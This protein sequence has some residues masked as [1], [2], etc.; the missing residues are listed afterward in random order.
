VTDLG[1]MM[2]NES[3]MLR[4]NDI[5]IGDVFSFVVP[6]LQFIQIP[7]IGVLSTSDLMLLAALPIAILRHPERLNRKPVP[8]ILT[9]GFFWFLGQVVTD[10]VRH[11][12]PEDYLR[13]WSKIF[14]LLVNFTVVWIVACRN[15]GR[16]VLYSIGLGMGAILSVYFHPSD[17]AV[18]SPWKF[19]LGIPV[20]LLVAIWAAHSGKH[21]YVGILLPLT[22]LAIVHSF[23]NVRSIALIT[24]ITAVYSLFQMSQARN[25]ARVGKANLAVL[26]LTVACGMWSFMLVYSHYVEQGIF[27][28]YAQRK[29]EIQKN[30]AA[31]LLLGGRSEILASGQAILDSPLLG[32]GSWARDPTYAAI[33]AEKR[34]ELGYKNVEGPGGKKD[35]LIPSHSHIFGGWV[36]AGVA[37][38]MFWLFVLVYTIGTLFKV[39][40]WEPLL[41]LFAFAGFLLIWDILFSPLGAPTRFISPYFMAAMVVLASL[42]DPQA[43]FGDGA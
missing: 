26:S 36:E 7:A 11:S 15:R 18:I 20:T 28:E 2:E 29:L 30:G 31:G 16:F 6:A 13:G 12:S 41:P 22:I 21:K 33:L 17:D 35:D 8:T 3:T 42:R 34:A 37:G 39:S 19:G 9:L 5:G 38:A 14:L 32:H 27:G 40:G 10:L 43:V 23:Q 4:K 24:F 1:A 25:H